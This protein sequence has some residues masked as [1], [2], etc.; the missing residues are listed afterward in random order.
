MSEPTNNTALG[1]QENIAG[2]LCYVAG[3]I[4]GIVFLVLEKENKFV[5]FH[6]MQSL[7]TF[8]ALFVISIV[9]GF[10]PLVGWLISLL[11]APLGLVLWILLMYKAFQGQKFKLPIIGD[12]AEQ[13]I[14]Q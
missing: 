6:A 4:T 9:A 12:F 8:L 13:Q 3:F 11:I 14:G 5:R 7:V 2:L 10:I 1:V